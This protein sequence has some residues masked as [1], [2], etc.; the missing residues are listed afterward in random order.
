MNS[1][2]TKFTLWYTLLMTFI[3]IVFAISSYSLLYVNLY[4]NLE[5]NIKK[6]SENIIN[7]YL[8]LAPDGE[9]TI[10]PSDNEATLSDKLHQSNLSLRIIDAD[11][12]I[13]TQFGVFKNEIKPSPSKI[14]TALIA[15]TISVS[16][17]DNA[18]AGRN[19]YLI[20]PID[21]NN[22]TVGVI[23]LSQ[24]ISNAFDALEQLTLI[25]IVGI[26]TSIVFSIFSGYYLGRRTLG[27]IN[28]LID[29]VEAITNSHDL[30]KRLPV[31]INYQDELTRLASTFNQ[32]LRQ[33]QKEFIR[34]KNFTA[35]VSH[36][37]RTPITII[38]GN[39]DLALRK[40]N[41]TPSQVSKTLHKIKDETKRINTIVDN[42]LEL[43]NLEHHDQIDYTP[44]NLPRLL[45]ELINNFQSKIQSQN[46][47][48][49]F[50]KP[51]NDKIYNINGDVILIKRL[52][53][54]IIENAIKYNRENG[55][56]IIK[57]STKFNK[58]QILVQ[59]TGEGIDTRDLP[60]IFD[61]HYQ[62]KKSQTGIKQ[63]VG[64]G[65]AIAKEITQTHGGQISA[66]SQKDIG[67]K[68][69]IIFPHHNIN[70]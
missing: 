22:E 12:N 5:S 30:E 57:L 47:Q 23:E 70:P 49:I 63:G 4:S 45:H 8:G 19:I 24:P 35:N 53:G 43:S 55:K 1:I 6:Q 40:K 29:N 41:L 62:A 69:K 42:M 9:L 7:Q 28:E 2:R 20:A 54:N 61:R 48:I 17:I 33:I 18:E 11:K 3:V 67:T 10:A 44:I 13:I 66:T 15:H 27:Y 64:L 46:I 14:N 59:D 31:P 26:L 60:Y 52:L 25:L 65:L 32:M 58:I 56:I 16:L 34:E 37:L 51:K 38:Q 39:V 21:K 36:D 68:I 50:K